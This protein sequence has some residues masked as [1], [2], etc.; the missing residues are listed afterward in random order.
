[1]IE[2]PHIE[3]SRQSGTFYVWGKL[4]GSNIRVEYTRK[5]GLAKFGRRNGLLD[6][7]MPILKRSVP[8]I[9]QYEDALSRVLTKKRREWERVTLFFEF[10]GPSSFAGYHPETETQQVALIDAAGPDGEFLLS[11]D[12]HD[13][14]SEVVPTAP[15][16]H[17]GP[18]GPEFFDKVR[19]SQLEGMPFEGVVC[20]GARDSRGRP[21]MFKVKSEAWYLRLKEHCNGDEA[22]FERLR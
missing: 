5:K 9:Q 21:A 8:L 22:M 4:D 3:G 16:L 13:L 7:S 20:K 14:F 18:V 11:R 17:V 12:F 6:D 2:Y 15:L 19:A 10:W 1:M